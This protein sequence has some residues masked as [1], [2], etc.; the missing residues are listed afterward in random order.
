[1]SVKDYVE[2]ENKIKELKQLKAERIALNIT[3]N[4]TNALIKLN[5]KSFTTETQKIAR[6]FQISEETVNLLIDET[7]QKQYKKLGQEVCSNWAS[8]F[9]IKTEKK[10]VVHI[11]ITESEEEDNNLIINSQ[12]MV[13][14]K[15]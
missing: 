2:L 7:N 10:D 3:I 5:L 11:D 9:D 1:M 6:I 4:K 12:I 15:L 14:Y 8:S 13:K